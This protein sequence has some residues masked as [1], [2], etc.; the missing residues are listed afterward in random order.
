LR[1]GI[2]ALLRE[3]DADELVIVSDI[4][5]HHQRLSSF[6]IIASVMWEM[7]TASH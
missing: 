7:K 5:H 3:T 2:E 6:E 4:Y 1:A